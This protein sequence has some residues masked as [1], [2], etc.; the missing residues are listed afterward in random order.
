MDNIPG[1]Y[2]LPK[3]QYWFAWDGQPIS[4]KIAIHP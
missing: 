1:I 4:V 3:Y 2:I